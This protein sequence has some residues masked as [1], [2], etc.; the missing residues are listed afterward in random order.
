MLRYNSI[1]CSGL[2]ITFVMLL[3]SISLPVFSAAPVCSANASAV[4]GNWGWENNGSCRVESVCEDTVPIGDGWGWNGSTSCRIAASGTERSG[5]ETA[6]DSSR[7]VDSPPLGDGWGWDGVQSCS[8]GNNFSQSF[9]TQSS[10]TPVNE[11]VDIPPVG[12]GWGWDGDGSCAVVWSVMSF[13]GW[14][15]LSSE[16]TYIPFSNFT[17]IMHFAMYPTFNGKL[18]VGDIFSEDNADQAVSAAHARNTKIILVIGGE[19]E[20]D[21]FVGAT[22]PANLHGFVNEVIERMQRHN[23][24][25]VSIDWEEDVIDSQLVALIKLL[26]TEFSTMKP[27]PILT[28]DVLSIL[29]DADTVA[30]IAPYVNSV[31]LMSYFVPNKIE[32]EFAF[33][34]SAGLSADKVVMGIGLF[35]GA[36]DNPVRVIQKMNYAR[37]QGFKGV[38]LWSVEFADWEGDLFRNYLNSRWR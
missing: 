21:K 5:A 10:F 17:H 13:P 1:Y 32:N 18:D 4:V 25:G 34:R 22:S 9:L 12:D 27:R 20:G 15:Q 2:K 31:N 8:V 30:E 19:G 16:P 28:I 37:S 24:D 7:C 33:Y 29:V 26:A 38:E 14:L 23:Y 35:D 36:D 6:N 3:F 11:C